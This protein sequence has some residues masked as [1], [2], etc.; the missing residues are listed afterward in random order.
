MRFNSSLADFSTGCFTELIFFTIARHPAPDVELPCPNPLFLPVSHT[1]E[2]RQEKINATR[3]EEKSVCVA[4][5]VY[6]RVGW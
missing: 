6:M 4:K 2:N 3:R 1:K 5:E